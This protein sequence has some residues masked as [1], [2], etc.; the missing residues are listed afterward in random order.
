MTTEK[1]NSTKIIHVALCL[2][3]T[4]IY[5]VLGDL[6]TLEFLNVPKIDANAIIYLFI[7]VSAILVSNMIYKKLLTSVD[8][9][10]DLE[11]RVS[12]YQTACI[13]RWAILEGAAL[14]ILFL[15]KE[16]LVIGLFLILYMAFAK[17]SLEDMKRDFALAG[18]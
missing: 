7:G 4:L 2:G 11:K 15:K 18:K 16:F 6:H 1:L 9:K 17:P 8:P 5:F 14:L 10:L 3:V 12:T 13:V